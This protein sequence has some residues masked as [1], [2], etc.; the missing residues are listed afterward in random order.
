MRF[1]RFR[2]SLVLAFAATAC[3]GQEILEVVGPSSRTIHAVVGQEIAV[4]LSTV[5]PGEFASPPSISGA[6][7]TFIN[8]AFVAP[9]VPA[10]AT[11]RFRFRAAA[12]G[13]SVVRFE[14]TVNAS[15][16][17]DTIIVR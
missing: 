11:Q 12:S 5:G 10:G 6:A 8:A 3:S 4:T 13:T 14:H 15:T 9:F 16:V 2:D 17:E 1:V 7:I